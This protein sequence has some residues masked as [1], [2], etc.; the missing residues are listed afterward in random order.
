[1]IRRSALLLAAL[2][3]LAGP[4]SAADMSAAQ[5]EGSVVWYSSIGLQY[6]PSIVAR[7]ESTHPG[8]KVQTLRAVA[9]LLPARII[10][11]Q[12]SGHYGAD[13]IN[14]DNIPM[15]QLQTAGA[16]DPKEPLRELYL[17][18]TILAWNPKKLA[19]DGL[20]A[21]SS[22]AD[23]AKPEWRGKIG[24]DATAYNWYQGVLE[25]APNAQATLK[26]IAENHPFIAAGHD[27]VLAQ[28]TAGEYDVT[29]TA[30]GF[31]CD[32]E[33][34]KGEPIVCFNPHPVLVDSSLVTLAK[35]APHPNAAHVLLD[36]L[37][38]KDGQQAI[39]DLTG[40]SSRVAGVRNNPR[41]WDPKMTIHLVST[42]DPAAYNALV[43]NYKAL[44]GID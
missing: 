32:A 19:A 9:N 22:L 10:T 34:L 11:E 1:M 25:T 24:I 2:A 23:L 5:R 8:I 20:K 6:L 12:K 38:S 17:N 3:L 18:T 39:V 27:A 13:L 43:S 4:V 31:L 41:I 28:L 35:N 33:R 16:L 26:A 30:Y 44:L 15:A 21:P 37:L 36:W 14:A 7:F 42:P 29:P 40:R